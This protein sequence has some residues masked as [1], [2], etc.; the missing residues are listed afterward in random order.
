MCILN[1]VS[2]MNHEVSSTSPVSIVEINVLSW[3]LEL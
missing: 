1:F 2:I 3:A